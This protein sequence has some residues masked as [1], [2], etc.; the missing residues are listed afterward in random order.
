MTDAERARIE[1][2]IRSAFAAVE[3]PGN[4]ALRGS[5][6]GAEPYRVEREF[7]DKNDWRTLDAAFLDSAPGGLGSALSFLSD[8][9]FR[10]FLPAYM[11]ADLADALRRVDVPFHLYFGLDDKMRGEKVNPRR[12]GDRTWFDDMRHRFSI[13]TPAQAHAIAEYLA[14]KARHDDIDFTRESIEQALRNY[15]RERAGEATG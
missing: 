14:Y 12:Y 8:E 9:A 10:Y 1:A 7:A 11:V 13:F 6:E 2:L 15:W 5:D 3:R 4:W